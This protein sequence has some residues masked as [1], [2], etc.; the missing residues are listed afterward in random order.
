[1]LR[2]LAYLLLLLALPGVALAEEMEV[3]GLTGSQRGLYCVLI[4]IIAYALVMAEE[5]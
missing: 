2:K 4:F 5:F 3:L 1:M